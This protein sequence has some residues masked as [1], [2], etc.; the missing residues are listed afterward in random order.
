MKLLHALF[1]APAAIA[2]PAAAPPPEFLA[3]QIVAEPVGAQAFGG[4]FPAPEAVFGSSPGE[5]VLDAMA[6]AYADAM[7]SAQCPRAAMAQ[8]LLVLRDADLH[9]PVFTGPGRKRASA[10]ACRRFRRVL[11]GVILDAAD[12]RDGHVP[13]A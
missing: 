2:A 7:A 4:D 10:K 5:A 8:A 6:A 13:L 11:D 3:P 1:G 9:D 12:R